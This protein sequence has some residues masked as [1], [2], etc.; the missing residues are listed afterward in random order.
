MQQLRVLRQPPDRTG[1]SPSPPAP[2]SPSPKS[3]LK[4]TALIVVAVAVALGLFDYLHRRTPLQYASFTPRPRSPYAKAQ[5]ASDAHPPAAHARTALVTGANGFTGSHLVEALL[6][7]DYNYTTVYAMHRPGSTTKLLDP[8]QA[9]FSAERLVYVEADVLDVPALRRAIP[10][11]LGVVFHA[12]A[13]LNFWKPH[14]DMQYRV[15]VLGTRNVVDVCLERNV[16]KLVHTSSVGVWG[17]RAASGPEA[18]RITEET[19]MAANE[20]FIAYMHTKYLAEL[21]VL[22]GIED[23]LWATILN[24]GAILGARDATSFGRLARMVYH[25]KLPAITNGINLGTDVREVVRAHV[26]AAEVGRLGERYIL[27]GPEVSNAEL[28]GMMARAM[29]MTADSVVVLPDVVMQAIGIVNEAVAAIT[30]REPEINIELCW[31]LASRGRFSSAKARD[32]LGFNPD[33]PVQD[34]V[35]DMIAWLAQEGYLSPESSN[36]D[37]A[38]K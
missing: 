9:Q 21:E 16:Q 29:N 12:A 19:P 34:A 5:R 33:A 32:Q 3:C 38:K 13:N 31:V 25:N 10:E 15:N 2:A 4:V 30:N 27:A 22:G 37:L 8:L 11:G 24:P 28:V 14:N 7:S 26:R 17:P 18:P 6:L 20:T 35:N 1:P 36:Q 23:G